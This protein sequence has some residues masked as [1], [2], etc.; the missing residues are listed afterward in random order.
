MSVV[1]G[2]GKMSSSVFSQRV[3]ERLARI[4]DSR[5][6]VQNVMDVHSAFLRYREDAVRREGK[7]VEGESATLQRE[8]E[9]LRGSLERM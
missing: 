1:T 5:D 2:S 8:V 7:Q 4:Q 9:V 3:E 6:R